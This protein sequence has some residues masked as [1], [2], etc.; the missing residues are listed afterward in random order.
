MRTTTMITALA[1]LVNVAVLGAAESNERNLRALEKRFRELPMEARRLTGPLFWLHGDENESAERLGMYLEKVAQGGNGCFTAES[2]PHSDW[3]GPR[4]YSDLDICLKKAKELDL[5]MWI[6]DEKWWPSQGVG[7]KVPPRYAAKQLEAAAVDAEGP[8]VYKGEGFAGER[9]IAAVAGKLNGDLIDGDSLVDLAGEINNGTLTWQV[10]EGKWRIMKFTHKQAPGLG[11]GGGRQLSVD[12]ASRDCAEWFIRTVYQ[13][14]Y[15]HFKEDFGKTIPGFFYDEPETRGDWGTEL[16]VVLK[17]RGI[18]WKKAYVAYK[19]KLAGDE[20][21][22]ARYQYMLAFAEAW[23]RVMYGGM[24]DWCRKHNVV[25]IGHFME[26]GYLYLRPDFCAGDMMLL[27]EYSDMGGIDAV[28]NQFVMGRRDARDAPCWQT[29]KL[30][31]SISHVY[32]KKDDVA[33]CEIFGARGQ[34]LSYPEMKWWTDHM[35]VSGINFMIPHSFNPRAPHDRDCPPYFY[36]GGFE[37]RWPLYRVWADYSSR[38]SLMLAG[39]R[40]VCP[41]ALLFSGNTRR[42]GKTVTPE[43]MT[44]AIQ[45]ALYDCDWMPFEVFENDAKISDGAIELYDERYKVL[46]VPPGEVITYPALLKARDFFNGGGTVVGYGMQPARSGTVG[47]SNVEIAA[48]CTEIWG[49]PEGPGTAVC[50]KGNRGGRSYFLPEKPTARDIDTVLRGDAG[51]P[52]VVEVLPGENGG[53]LHVLHRVKEG[54]DIF[55]ICNQ[56]HEG[57]AREFTLRMR[58]RGVP[59]CWDAMRNE[60]A[61]VPFG[62]A[63]KDAVDVRLTLQP[64]ESVL[65]VF[66]PEKRELPVRGDYGDGA[67]RKVIPVTR[68]VTPPELLVP[69]SPPEAEKPAENAAALNGCLWIWH[70]EGNAAQAAPPGWCFFRRRLTVPAGAKIRAAR[71]RGTSDNQ[72]ILYVNGKEAG[73]SGSDMEGWRVPVRIDIA[74][75]LRPGDNV[76]AIAALN[77]TDQ[78]SPA[79]LIG[80]IEIDYEGGASASIATD[81]KWKVSREKIDEWE[82]PEFSDGSWSAAREL[83]KYG[84]APWGQLSQKGRQMLTTS[85]VKSD[86]FCGAFTIPADADLAG[87]R[88]YVETSAPAPECAA[89][90]TVNGRYAGGFIGA[91]C[92]LEI[93]PLLNPGLNRIV[94]EPF[95]PEAVSVVIVK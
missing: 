47:R 38:L 86:P 50:R 54:R 39:G 60:I 80:R 61:A 41:V 79:G 88:V 1:V 18:D 35:Q 26:H 59:E 76:L 20:D 34:D 93:G 74:E 89:S 42:V 10:P 85:P 24:S 22:A 62:R 11:Q 40:H 94:L 7:G 21:V 63:V 46:V 69:S 75:L 29:P 78:P 36:N 92:R 53:W 51:I 17:E 49:L 9:Y 19:F 45:D 31:S 37:P 58:A 65:I 8:S 14:H 48:L 81:G 30:G 84:C 4:W 68:E 83:G 66:N 67:S 25:S 23:G 77:M 91:P 5:Q 15:D 87:A 16:D 32:G 71:F 44:S 6:F 72:L 12:G 56:N 43:D 73:R 82:K 95:A 33:M 3:L 13:P 27:Q 57:E 55:F 64:S 28:F 90:V 70:P 2:R 52:P